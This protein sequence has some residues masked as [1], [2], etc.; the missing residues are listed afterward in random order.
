MDLEFDIATPSEFVH[1]F[2]G[3]LETHKVAVAVRPDTKEILSVVGL[4]EAS[5]GKIIDTLEYITEALA[6]RNA[7][8][9][10]RIEA[11]ALSY[12]SFFRRNGS[13]KLNRVN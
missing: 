13:E 2:V 8:D 4:T 3:Y 7:L 11:L 1:E 9:G 6:L 5:R 10:E 12:L